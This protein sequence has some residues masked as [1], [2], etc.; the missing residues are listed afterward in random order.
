[1]TQQVWDVVIVGAGPIGGRCASLL[2]ERGHSVLLLEEH[3]EIGRPFQCA[4]LVNPRAMKSVSLEDTI[5]QEIDGALIHGPSGIL[6]PV[7]ER[8]KP[9]TFVVC[10]KRF[11]QGVVQQSLEAG[12]HIWLNSMPIDASVNDE[13]VL[14]KVNNDGNIVDLKCKLLLGC[15]G[16]HSWT[17]R[18]F[19]MGKPK[20]LMIG[21]QAEVVGYQN[22]DRWLEMYSGS[23]VAPGF[24]AWVV[25]SGFG[26]H[27]I[28]IWSTAEHLQGRSVEQCYH[29]LLKHP[30]WAERFSTVKETARYCGPI[31]CGMVK[32]PV[33]NRV[34]LVGD[35]AGM[36]KPTTGG[37]IGPGFRQIE[38][39]I[40]ELSS[41]IANDKLSTKDLRKITSKQWNEMKRVQDKARA[42]R[43]LLVSNCTD[44][45][46]DEHF[47]NFSRP[48]VLE[49]INSIGDIEKPVPL[50]MALLK[51]VP[52]FRKLAIKAGVK[53]LFT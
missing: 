13:G 32:N 40:E 15:D 3:S 1:M 42:L 19:K 47:K 44:E 12:A 52:A 22:D 41:A 48:D 8:N 4:G 45:E 38:M 39:I 27:R 16:A 23:K 35:A 31:P 20:E 30:L 43:D 28:G 33:K 11:D 18:Y 2:S 53:L 14:L 26:T 49:L 5:L 37:G 25:P 29:D 21:F 10:R 9:R 24:F 34:M 46:L 17:R 6:V 36:A 50:G 7:G 51:K